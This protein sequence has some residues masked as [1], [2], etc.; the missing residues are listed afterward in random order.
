[1]AAQVY[2]ICLKNSQ[3]LFQPRISSNYPLGG[4]RSVS[5]F[6]LRRTA[7]LSKAFEYLVDVSHWWLPHVETIMKHH[8]NSIFICLRR[9]KKDTI[10]SFL[11][12]KGYGKAGAINHWMRHD[13]KKWQFNFWDCAYPKYNVQSMPEALEQYWNH[14]YQTCEQL[15]KKYPS[16]LNYLRP[17]A[18]QKKSNKLEF[19]SFV[20][21]KIQSRAMKSKKMSPRLLT[22]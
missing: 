17:K 1:M 19:W 2:T 7:L 3:I 11:K 18:Y 4:R 16:K 12:I 21:I 14:Y 8:P 22:E 9:N 15:E 10:N 20:I 6:H 5:D 13:G